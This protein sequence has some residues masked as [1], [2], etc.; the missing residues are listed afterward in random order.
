MGV[1]GKKCR[2]DRRLAAECCQKT[3]GRFWLGAK[4]SPND[5]RQANPLTSKPRGETDYQDTRH[6]LT[7]HTVLVST[8]VVSRAEKSPRTHYPGHLQSISSIS[9][10]S[11]RPTPRFRNGQGPVFLSVPP[12]AHISRAISGIAAMVLGFAIS[13]RRSM[14]FCRTSPILAAY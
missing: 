14:M 6:T 1:V 13:H 10:P 7:Y 12:V 8:L 2:L 9:T 5:F 3:G 4:S 11:P